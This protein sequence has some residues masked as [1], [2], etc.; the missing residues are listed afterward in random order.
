ME[1]QSVYMCFPCYKEF[2]TLEEVLKHQ[3]T[4]TAEEDQAD[5]SRIAPV[6]VPVL[7]TQPSLAEETIVPQIQVQLEPLPAQP[8]ENAM[9][10]TDTV[11]QEAELNEDQ[12]LDQPRILYQC[13]DCEELFKSLDLWQHHR[14]EGACLRTVVVGESEA[15]PQSGFQP[16]GPQPVAEG[17]AGDAKSDQTDASGV[18]GDER[19]VGESSTG[20]GADQAAP[21][22]I[23][24]SSALEESSP[25]RRGALKK[26]KPDPVLLCVDCG[27]CFGLVSELVAHRKTHGFEE[28]LHHCTVCGESF[29]NTTLFLYHRKQ[30]RQKGEGSST[31]AS[32][33]SEKTYPQNSTSDGQEPDGAPSS[34]SAQP[35][36]LFLCLQCGGSF[37]SAAVLAAHRKGMHDLQTPLHSCSYC[38]ETFMNTTQYLYHRRQHRV[39]ECGP[40]DEAETGDEMASPAEE[41]PSSKRPLSLAPTSESDAPP[42]KRSR[43]VYRIISKGNKDSSGKE[44]VEAAA[45][46]TVD[47][48]N[49]PPPAKLLQDWSRTALPHVCPYCG[50]TF[51]RR[52]FLRTHVYSHTGEKLFTCKVCSKS[53]TNSQSLLRHTMSHSGNRPFCCD[54]CGKDFTQA[55]TLKRHQLIHTSDQPRRKRGRKPMCAADGD[56]GEGLFSCPLC[57]SHFNTEEQL[58]HHKLLHTSNPF[59][60]PDCGEAFS[61]RK[62]LDL[63]SLIHQDKEPVVCPHCSS[64]FINESVL[65]IHQQRCTGSEEERNTGRGRGQGRGRSTGQ[66]ECDL[67]GHRCMTQEGLDLHRLSHTGQTP[68]KC[69]VRPCRRRFISNKALEEHVLAHCQGKMSKPKGRVRFECEICF[70]GFAYNS[71]FQVHMRTHTNERPFE[72]ST[73]GKCFRQ[74]PHLQD[75]ERIHSGVRPFCCWICGKSFSVAARLTEHARTHS[76]EKPYPCP[77]CPAAFRSRSNLD[78]HIRQHG[79]QAAQAA[80][81]VASAN[82]AAQVQKVLEGAKVLSSLAA[83]SEAAQ[84]E[85]EDDCGGMQTI[86]VLQA[87]EGGGEAVMIPAEELSGMDGTSQVVIL[88]SSMLGAQGITI[89]TIT[90]DGTEIT[91]MD[92]SQSPQHSIEFIVEETI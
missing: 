25:R 89:P 33:L 32:S 70:K 22:V 39:L 86:Y 54:V 27:S 44:E 57:P 78:K 49:L 62:D 26:P 68:L 53:F 63:H 6:I 14:K 55:A 20:D 51:T 36:E 16:E 52:V 84:V 65:E 67:C 82:E 45:S 40:I 75:H 4:C 66:I 13:G 21:E 34:S 5:S 79:D 58:N 9:L 8:V 72:C 85:V 64:Q 35:T 77:N 59:P 7:Q 88:P 76:G 17:D 3:M 87:G 80:E 31:V 60:C 73:C 24:L 10:E 11:V 37:N 74:L 38:T 19:Q 81:E 28:A 71:T 2:N 46:A 1:T 15:E 43:P 29:L 47:T 48:A 42:P 18:K 83:T 56:S 23:T 90:M 69:P 91:M 61:R 41:A 92:G 12:L 30:H 50:K